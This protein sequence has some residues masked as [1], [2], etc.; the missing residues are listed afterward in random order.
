MATPGGSV[1]GRKC[2]SDFAL[3]WTHVTPDCFGSA[4]RKVTFL[5]E[6]TGRAAKPSKA[7]RRTQTHFIGDTMAAEKAEVESRY[8]KRT[9]S[10]FCFLISDLLCASDSRACFW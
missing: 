6:V 10:A 2:C 9:Y 4:S 7:A 3:S 5:S 8:C 1:S